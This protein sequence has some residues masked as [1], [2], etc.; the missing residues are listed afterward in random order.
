MSKDLENYEC[1]G[2]TDIFDF[3]EPPEGFKCDTCRFYR[4]RRWRIKAD[5]PP[6]MFCILNATG[7][8]PYETFSPVIDCESYK[9][10]DNKF[11]CCHTC[12][13]CNSFMV[14]NCELTNNGEE[15]PN[16]YHREG[17]PECKDSSDQFSY[18]DCR[19]WD[20]CD[21]YKPKSRLKDVELR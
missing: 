11:K 10:D 2:Q 13:H 14:C 5:E 16:R 12:E 19:E 18:F 7:I 17:M 8:K 21:S 1:D 15:T 4:D 20:I 9:P 3:L 6:V